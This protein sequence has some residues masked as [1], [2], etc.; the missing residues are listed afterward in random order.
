MAPRRVRDSLV[1][2][3]PLAG[4]THAAILEESMRVPNILSK[5]SMDMLPTFLAWCNMWY[6]GPSPSRLGLGLGL[7][8]HRRAQLLV[9]ELEGVPVALPPH[10]HR[11]AGQPER[12]RHEAAAQRSAMPRNPDTYLLYFTLLYSPEQRDLGESELER[13]LCARVGGDGVARQVVHLKR[14]GKGLQGGVKGCEG[15]VR[16]CAGL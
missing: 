11:L 4:I 3:P 16:G 5:G 7:G 1:S 9:A 10:R 12:E 15:A 14:G 6:T 8:P 13:R 2:Q